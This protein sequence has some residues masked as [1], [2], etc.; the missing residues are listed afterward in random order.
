M[1][2]TNP[3]AELS[4]FNISPEAM[5]YYIIAMVILVIG[6][7]ILDMWHKKSAQYFFRNYQQ[8]KKSATKEISGGEVGLIAVKTLVEDVALSGEFG[9]SKR[10]IAHLITMYGFIIFVA[11][12]AIIA[13]SPPSANSILP[14]LWHIGAIMLAIGSWWFWLFIRVDVVAEANKR[15]SLAPMD[16]FSL[17]L[18]STSLLALLWSYSDNNFLL[19]SL[20]IIASTLLFGTVL[21]SKFAHM[22]FKPAAAF[23]KRLIEADGSNENLPTLSR[24]D[25]AQRKRHSMELLKDAPM[26]MGL[27]IDREAP[28][29]Y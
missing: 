15:F 1:I 27:G 25:P 8:G 28:R 12:T 5:Q 18:M 6:G 13:F 3:F 24:D 11:T 23:N 26:D 9:R 10:R 16:I 19:F 22:F 7:T 14:V 4:A 17:G 29:N 20:F 21:W 2:T